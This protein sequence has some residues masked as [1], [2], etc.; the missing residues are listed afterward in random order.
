MG[1]LIYSMQVSADGYVNGPRKR[2]DW[3]N[4][5]DEVLEFI[6]ERM[7]DVGAYVYGRRYYETMT[8][9]ANLRSVPGL[10]ELDYRFS[11]LW[12]A[13]PKY[14]F[15]TTLA[16]PPTPHTTLLRE[17]DSGLLRDLAE[18]SEKH[19][20]V[21]GASIGAQCLR[22]GIIDGISTYVVP[23]ATGEGTPFWPRDLPLGLRLVDERRFASG[24]VNLRY[25]PIY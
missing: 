19:V 16:E 14:V 4:P 6:H 7:R 13:T 1:K 24:I 11:D 3:A 22:A 15:S 20:T 2:F 9:W 25:A 17:F 8:S 5:D 23:I 18:A 21:E 10:K 12:N